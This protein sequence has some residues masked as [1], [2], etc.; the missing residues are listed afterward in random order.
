ME[1]MTPRR[2]SMPALVCVSVLAVILLALVIV[3]F[4]LPQRQAQPAPTVI[5]TEPT[6]SPTEPTLPPPPA[7][8]YGYFD[9][10]YENG[11]LTCLKGESVLGIDVSAH[12]GVVDWQ[13][14]AAAGI[15]FVMLRAGYRGYETGSL[16]A[17][18]MAQEN[19]AG[20]KAAGLQVGA[21]FFSQATSVEEAQEEADFFLDIIRDWELDLYAVYDWEYISPDARTAGLDRRTVTDCTLT[22]CRRM[23]SEGLRPMVYFNR[24]QAQDFLHLEELTDYPFWLA[25]YSGRMTYPYKL[26]MWQY[27]EKGRVPGI[28]GNVDID[29]HFIYE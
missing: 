18:A 29:L 1:T 5:R 6:F 15:R 22:F 9:F 11:Y 24:H 12:Q 21:Y 16:V 7:N 10:Q 20:A 17:D 14:V 26:A 13:Q 28:D 3:A 8:P 2:Y 27:T 23:E 19:Y 4:S 25:L